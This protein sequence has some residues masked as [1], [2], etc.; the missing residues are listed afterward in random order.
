MSDQNLQQDDI[1]TRNSNVHLVLEAPTLDALT[2]RISDIL[3]KNP[4]ATFYILHER[5]QQKQLFRI[6]GSSHKIIFDDIH[7]WPMRADVLA[8]LKAGL[9]ATPVVVD[10]PKKLRDLHQPNA[11]VA[12]SDQNWVN[13]TILKLEKAKNL[14][15]LSQIDILLHKEK[16]MIGT[17]PH[18]QDYTE[19]AKGQYG[20]LFSG[21][22]EQVGLKKPI[23]DDTKVRPR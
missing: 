6:D 7:G 20:R 17:K 23:L 5:G 11:L 8:A 21:S 9:A 10:L 13:N 22:D 1:H 3:Q 2:Q 4:T 19:H 15:P 12:I 14:D 18:A 16:A